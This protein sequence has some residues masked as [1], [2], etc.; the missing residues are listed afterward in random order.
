MTLHKGHVTV[1][2][3]KQFIH[4]QGRHRHPT[5]RFGPRDYLNVVDSE[6]LAVWE[7]A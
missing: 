7:L 4:G 6:P 5:N 2:I 1:D 3:G